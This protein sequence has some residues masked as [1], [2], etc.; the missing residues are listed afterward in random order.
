MLTYLRVKYNRN[1]VKVVYNGENL[2]NHMIIQYWTSFSDKIAIVLLN[3]KRFLYKH[4][5]YYDYIHFG[6]VP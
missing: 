4:F 6:S 2:S 3:L 1:F 5:H